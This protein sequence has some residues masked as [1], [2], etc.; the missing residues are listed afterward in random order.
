MRPSDH[1]LS[2]GGD[3]KTTVAV[4]RQRSNLAHTILL[5]LK[6]SERFI[7]TLQ[8]TLTQLIRTVA[9]AGSM[10][11]TSTAFAQKA[12]PVYNANI[13]EAEVLAVQK[14]WGDALIQ[15]SN[16]YIAGGF[17]KAK[18]TASAVLDAAYGYNMGPV[19]FKP[20]LTVAP[21]TFRITKEGA[22]SYFVGG[23][24][25][26]PRD[27]GFALKGWKQVDIQNAAIHINGDVASTMGNV[28]F[29]DKDGKKTVVDKTWAFKKDDM[30]K[31]R[32]VVHHSSLPYAGS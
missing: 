2:I 3:G 27:T 1:S 11:L 30:G 28:T 5:T 19:L 15:I 25:N 22:L 20:T 31:I 14:D 32:I 13:T 4:V 21:Q 9:L 23:D 12:A 10:A 8:P 24:T 26:Y 16:D 17:A 29:T 6:F 7:M 18:A